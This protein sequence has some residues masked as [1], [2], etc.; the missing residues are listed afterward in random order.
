VSIG[1][2]IKT[3]SRGVSDGIRERTDAAHGCLNSA[4][5]SQRSS[6]RKGFS[7]THWAARWATPLTLTRPSTCSS[8][9]AS[10]EVTTAFKV[11]VL[12]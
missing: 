6:M 4:S 3:L 7:G 9:E 11:N 12:L 2:S 10:T 8:K 5:C 1:F